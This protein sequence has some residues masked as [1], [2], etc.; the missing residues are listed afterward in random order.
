[1]AE[2]GLVDLQTKSQVLCSS[3]PSTF[4]KMDESDP[5]KKKHLW[6]LFYTPGGY[7][8]SLPLL[9][10]FSEMLVIRRASDENERDAPRG[11]LQVILL[12]SP[13]NC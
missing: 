11:L 3:A 12:V 6:T 2:D 1:M 9:H 7:F 13:R 10:I 4:T 8:S 5:M